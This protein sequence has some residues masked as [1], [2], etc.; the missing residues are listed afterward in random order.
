MNWR[1]SFVSTMVL[2]FRST[3]FL[4]MPSLPSLL[5]FFR[6]E[7]EIF[8]FNADSMLSLLSSLTISYR[9]HIHI[10]LHVRAILL[11]IRVFG[12]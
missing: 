4:Y 10:R 6:R 3:I 5:S 11:P 1:M 9:N 8:L 12:T 2:R 7:L